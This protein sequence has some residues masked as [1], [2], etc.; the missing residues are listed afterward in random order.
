M[1]KAALFVL[2]IFLITL[3]GCATGPHKPKYVEYDREILEGSE[4]VVLL[5]KATQKKIRLVDDASSKTDDGRLIVKVKLFNKTSKTLR[6]QMQTLYLDSTGMTLE[7]ETNWQLILIPANSYGYYE[8][9]SLNDRAS[10]YTVRC[11][12]V[13]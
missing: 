9:T 3:S 10:K 8:T 2:A 1:Y 11:K 4:R 13:N 7:D 6:L 12:Y 5:D